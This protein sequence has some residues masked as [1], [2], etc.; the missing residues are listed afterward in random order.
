MS[1]NAFM[2]K[3]KIGNGLAEDAFVMI[4]ESSTTITGQCLVLCGSRDY[5]MEGS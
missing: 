1:E 3:L 2:A 5:A 4:A